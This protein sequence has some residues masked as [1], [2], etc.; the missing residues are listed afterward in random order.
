MLMF[1]VVMFLLVA[2]SCWWCSCVGV[3]VR[4]GVLVAGVFLGGGLPVAAV[5]GDSV[6]VGVP[7]VGGVLVI[8]GF[9]VVGILVLATESALLILRLFFFALII[10]TSVVA[11]ALKSNI[12]QPLLIF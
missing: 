9:L 8:D 7:V 11:W 5:L 4:G 3:L 6:P 12:Y 10:M 1:F 2:C